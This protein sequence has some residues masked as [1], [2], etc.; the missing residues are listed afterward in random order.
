MAIDYPVKIDIHL[1]PVWHD[2][3]PEIDIGINDDIER[4][5]LRD[6]QQ[7]HYEFTAN[8]CSTLCVELLNKTD[9]DSRPDQGL[10]KAVVIESVSFFDIK[11]DRF[12]WLG[13]YCPKYPEPWYS[14]QTPKPEPLLK[15]HT[16]L[17]WN[18]KWTL[19]FDVPDFT[20]I[21]RVQNLGWIYG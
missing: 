20:W 13:E 17:G 14:E 19:T 10:D 21:H 6:N 7:F 11:D 18:G 8:N 3:P 15:N 1:R 16:Y 2:D 5:I 9:A 4:I 12:I